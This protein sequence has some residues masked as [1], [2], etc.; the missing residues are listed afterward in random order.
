M[1]ISRYIDFFDLIISKN[2]STPTSLTV[3]IKS[4]HPPILP[5]S[6]SPDAPIECISISER[7][8][9]TPRDIKEI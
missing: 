3:R 8:T 5:A 1:E 2:L 7:D 4:T 9:D 6:A